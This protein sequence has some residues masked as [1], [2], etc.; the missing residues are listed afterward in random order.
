MNLHDILVFL[1]DFEHATQRLAIAADLA[2]AHAATLIGLRI[3]LHPQV[4]PPLRGFLLNDAVAAHEAAMRSATDRL[5]VALDEAAATRGV[6]A[7]WRLVEQGD[8]SDIV[9][10]ARYANLTVVNKHDRRDD[11]EFPADE[12]IHDLL[13]RS[14]RPVLIAPNWPFKGVAGTRAVIAWNGRR[15]ASRALADAMP[16]LAKAERVTLVVAA[17]DNAER[18]IEFLRGHL[19]RNGVRAAPKVL[20]SEDSIDTGKNILLECNAIDANLLVMGGYSR[21]RLR[22]RLFGGVTEF[23]LYHARLPVLMSH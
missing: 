23:V 2:Q 14:G 17:K 6:A 13:V 10:H 18:E 20:T 8:A 15:E 11:E 19:G 22:E 7:E 1:D 21:S 3:E 9:A 4:P 12:L 5:R 16:L